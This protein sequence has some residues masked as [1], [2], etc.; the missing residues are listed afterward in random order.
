MAGLT[1][2]EANFVMASAEVSLEGGLCFGVVIL[3]IVVAGFLAVNYRKEE[4]IKD[5]DR[6]IGINKGIAK[7]KI[8]N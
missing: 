3:L 1:T 7:N 4:S 2:S 8:D 6:D 5:E